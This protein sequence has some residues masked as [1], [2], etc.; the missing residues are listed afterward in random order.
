MITLIR[1]EEAGFYKFI[2][3]HSVESNIL[4]Y[5]VHGGK[6]SNDKIF[7]DEMLK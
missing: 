1:L 2:K 4:K 7:E 3:M 6:L 5:E